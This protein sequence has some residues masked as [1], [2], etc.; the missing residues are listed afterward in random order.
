MLRPLTKKQYL[1]VGYIHQFVDNTT[2]ETKYVPCSQA[3][4]EAVINFKTNVTATLQGCTFVSSS[5][6]VIMVDNPDTVL[7]EDEYCDYNGGYYVFTRDVRGILV[8][9]NVLLTDVT[10]DQID[11]S[12]I[13]SI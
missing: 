8:G 10:N 1:G 5:G 7:K 11:P 3:D 6:G 13:K 4:Y 2:G 12:I 9:V